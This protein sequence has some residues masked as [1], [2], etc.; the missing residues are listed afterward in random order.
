[1]HPFMA[2]VLSERAL[3]LY[4]I[5]YADKTLKQA[6]QEQYEVLTELFPIINLMQNGICNPND[7]NA[8][9]PR[10]LISFDCFDLYNGMAI[11]QEQLKVYYNNIGNSFKCDRFLQLW[12]NEFDSVKF[13]F[14]FA[15]RD[16]K[17]PII[18]R[19]RIQVNLRNNVGRL[20][21]KIS[22]H[23]N[24]NHDHHLG[25][26]EW[27]LPLDTYCKLVNVQEQYNTVY[28]GKM[29]I[30]EIMKHP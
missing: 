20:R 26:M 29:Y 13:A 10:N 16:N 19:F 24:H 14:Q 30:M 27:I 22:C 18:F 28:E 12:P 17:I 8:D 23:M 21:S 1:M 7:V 25:N 9:I 3:S 11:T 6:F 15:K 5:P 2:G 4:D